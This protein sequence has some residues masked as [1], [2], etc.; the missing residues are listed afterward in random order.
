MDVA[1]AALRGPTDNVSPVKNAQYFGLALKHDR[2][3]L[4]ELFR[5]DRPAPPPVSLC[6]RDTCRFIVSTG[7]QGNT[8]A[9]AVDAEVSHVVGVG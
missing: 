9:L 1:I 4:D 2:I 5:A 8:G 3:R 6:E 7:G